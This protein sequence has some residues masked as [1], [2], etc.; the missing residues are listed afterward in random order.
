[1]KHHIWFENT[2]MEAIANLVKSDLLNIKAEKRQGTDD[3]YKTLKTI[4]ARA[5]KDTSAFSKEVDPTVLVPPIFSS[6]TSPQATH[7]QH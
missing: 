7:E 1:M 6:Q 2:A 3:T 4:L 5:Q